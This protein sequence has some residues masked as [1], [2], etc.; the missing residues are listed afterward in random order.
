LLSST[1]LPFLPSPSSPS[2]SKT[3]GIDPIFNLISLY[4]STSLIRRLLHPRSSSLSLTSILTSLSSPSPSLPCRSPPS[5]SDPKWTSATTEQNPTLPRKPTGKPGRS[6]RRGNGNLRKRRQNRH[7][8][9]RD[10][11][12]PLDSRSFLYLFQWVLI[13]DSLGKIRERNF[14]H[15]LG[16]L[17]KRHGSG[18]M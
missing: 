3:L 10:L 8:L 17:A 6:T 15:A 11:I 7:R 1:F 9:L 16:S 14:V 13:R 5:Q 18:A 12:R 2:S 4:T